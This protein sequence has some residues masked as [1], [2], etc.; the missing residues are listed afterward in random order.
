[1][2]QLVSHIEFLLHEHNCVIIPEFGGFVVNTLSARR[3]GIAAFHAPVC[4]LVFNSDLT[5]NDGLLAQS[6]M[7]ADHLTFESATRKIE[8]AVQELKLQLYEQR[9]VELAKLGSFN[10]DENKRI[11]YTPAAFVRPAFFGLTKATLKPVIQLQAPVSASKPENRRKGIRAASVSAVAVAVIAVLMFVLPVSD[12]TM[13]RQSAQMLSETGLFRSKPAQTV[14]QIA[15]KQAAASS[16]SPTAPSV[17]LPEENITETGPVYQNGP[18]YYIV[19]GVYERSDVAQQITESLKGEGFSQTAWLE[20]P[21]RIDVY[22]ASF[23]DKTEAEEY[24]RAL[25]KQYPAHADAWIL[26]R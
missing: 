14:N 25:H 4:E 3:D 19:M 26:K 15:D 17:T 16:E 13:G 18:A 1:M 22:T 20:R 24:L 7:K 6:Y 2:N 5:H 11:I 8:Q 9:R 23:T 21:G 12:T 10:I